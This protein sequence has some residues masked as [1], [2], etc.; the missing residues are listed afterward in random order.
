LDRLEDG[1]GKN[2]YEGRKRLKKGLSAIQKSVQKAGEERRRRVTYIRYS[3]LQRKGLGE[4]GRRKDAPKK[5]VSRR[6][7]KLPTRGHGGTP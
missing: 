5:V 2:G 6:D 1:R 3:N 4:R 7:K